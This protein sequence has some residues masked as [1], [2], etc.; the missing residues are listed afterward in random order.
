MISKKIELKKFY[1]H[2]KLLNDGAVI[3]LC[4]RQSFKN[5]T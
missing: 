4:N 1:L 2:A 3:V 5:L